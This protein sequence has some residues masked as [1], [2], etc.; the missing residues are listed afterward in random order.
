[1]D[2]H[3]KNNLSIGVLQPFE[4]LFL[5]VGVTGLESYADDVPCFRLLEK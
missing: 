1:M 3:E 5:L 2:L 4:R